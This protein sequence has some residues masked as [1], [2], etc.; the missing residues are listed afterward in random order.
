MRFP[1]AYQATGH[2][3]IMTTRLL[4]LA[5][6][7]LRP[8]SIDRLPDGVWDAADRADLV[9]HAGDVVCV[10]LLQALAGCA[11]VHAV[12]GNNDVG[13]LELPEDLQITVENVTIAMV[14]DSRARAGREQRVR[15]WYPDA[16]L[17]IFGHSHE[18]I[19]AEG[20]HGQRLFNPGS[21][22][23]RRR[24][25]RCSFGWIEIDGADYRTDVRLID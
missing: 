9:L 17:V 13:H 4:V 3:G 20:E 21:A 10:E 7:H 25:P 15:R 2:T 22:I 18:P 19:D 1:P 11:P 14:H 16:H 6:T 8:E 5:D 24:Q 12:Q 23:Q